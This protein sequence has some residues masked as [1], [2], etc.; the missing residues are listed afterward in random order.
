M[1]AQQ[2][3]DELRSMRDTIEQL[4][5][6]MVYKAGLYQDAKVNAEVAYALQRITWQAHDCLRAVNPK[7]ATAKP[8]AV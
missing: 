5:Q 7:P 1:D 6:D 2:T 3:I 8:A 4:M